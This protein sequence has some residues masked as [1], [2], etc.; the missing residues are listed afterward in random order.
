MLLVVSGVSAARP[1]AHQSRAGRARGPGSHSRRG[2]CRRQH[3]VRR[4]R[5]C[6]GISV[7]GLAELVTAPGRG[8][9]MPVSGVLRC[10]WVALGSVSNARHY[11]PVLGTLHDSLCSGASVLQGAAGRLTS[12]RDLG[13]RQTDSPAAGRVPRGLP[14]SATLSGCRA[15][16]RSRACRGHRVSRGRESRGQG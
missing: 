14:C 11:S 2:A 6:C 13:C 3:S 9:E 4:A 12:C 8:R 1:P 10:G 15:G 5:H 7:N 16:P